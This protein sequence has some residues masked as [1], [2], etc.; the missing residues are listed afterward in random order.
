[1]AV[2][3]SQLMSSPIKVVTKTDGLVRTY[4]KQRR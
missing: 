2:T 1:M 3:S 4:T